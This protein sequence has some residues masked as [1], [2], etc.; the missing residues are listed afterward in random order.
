MVSF[1]AADGLG[2]FPVRYPS[3]GDCVKE[4]RVR[5][6]LPPVPILVVV[7]TWREKLIAKGKL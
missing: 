2:S 3:T 7:L 4:E 6:P 5:L 1:V